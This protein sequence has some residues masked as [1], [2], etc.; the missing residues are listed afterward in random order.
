MN[1]RNRFLLLLILFLACGSVLAQSYSGDARKIGMGGIGYSENITT[2]MIEAE[3]PYGSVVI[4]LGIV[5]A[6][7]ERNHFDPNDSSFDPVFVLDY[8]ASPLHYT[9]GRNP[10]GSLGRFVEDLRQGDLSLN[11]NTYRGFAPTNNLNAEGLAS[12]NWGKTVKVY[13]RPDGT[14]HGFYVGA[15]PYISAKTALSVDQGLT[16]VLASPTDVPAPLLANRHFLIT[17]DS[18]GQLA[19]AVTGGYRGRIALPGRAG[20]SPRNGI[21]LGANYNFLRGFRYETAD[22]TFRFD[23]DPSGLLMVQPTTA[24]ATVDNVRSHSGTGFALDFGVGAVVERWEFGFGANGVANRIE[25]KNL[26]GNRYALQSLVQGG[27]F[28]ESSLPAGPARLTVKLPV[29]YVANGG[30]SRESWSAVAE[31]AN[32]FQGTSLHGGFEYRFRRVQLRG[33]GRYGLDRWHPAGG[34]GLNLTERVCLDVAAF[35][36]TTNIERKM[37]PALAVSFRFNRLE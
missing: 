5:Q 32:G 6:L 21:Y 3:R 4:P 9:F 36:T 20:G 15:G 27:D 19:L 31:V 24:P 10:G 33:G 30:Y 37:R 29:E 11:L 2:N 16:D 35:G 25:W 28:I 12:P 18:V 14:F 22:M 26:T 8:A 7:Q 13:K 23:T 34:I 1:I 17:D